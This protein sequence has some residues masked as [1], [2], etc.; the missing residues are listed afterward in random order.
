MYGPN[1]PVSKTCFDFQPQI[2]AWHETVE[3]LVLSLGS[4]PS[5][6]D[7]NEA[8]WR[9]MCFNGGAEEPAPATYSH[10]YEA[11]KRVQVVTGTLGSMSMG[12]VDPVEMHQLVASLERDLKTAGPLEMMLSRYQASRSFCITEKGYIGWVS[13]AAR[14]G[15]L[16]VAFWGTR[17]L[18]TLRPMEGGYRFTGDCYLQ[19]LMEGEALRTNEFTDEDIVIV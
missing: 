8:L 2:Q 7:L 17:L 18:Y 16:V 5:D 6:M 4:Y 12:G 11:W 19:E 1:D 9:A 13:I 3:G 10:A 14:E 15:D